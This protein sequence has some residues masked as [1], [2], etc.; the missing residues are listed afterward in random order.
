L[1]L[2][3]SAKKNNLKQR[4]KLQFL[5]FIGRN[6]EFVLASRVS[7]LRARTR[8]LRGYNVGSVP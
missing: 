7:P 1:F 6:E 2:T 4:K 8:I 3:F 5:Y